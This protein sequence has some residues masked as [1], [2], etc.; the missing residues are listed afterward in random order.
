M[1]IYIYTHIYTHTYAYI[2]LYRYIHIY[3]QAVQNRLRAQSLRQESSPYMKSGCRS[4]LFRK[5]HISGCAPLPLFLHGRGAMHPRHWY[6]CEC[7]CVYVCVCVCARAC[8]RVCVSVILVVVLSI[9][10]IVL[11]SAKQGAVCV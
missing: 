6:V 3:I 10:T 11:C 4:W 7:V 1:N 8:V 5:W 9:C 2:Y